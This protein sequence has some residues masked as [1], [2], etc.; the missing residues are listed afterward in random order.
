MALR[1]KF[2]FWG[3]LVPAIIVAAD[4][5]SKAWALGKFGVPHNIC[6]LNPYPQNHIEVSAVFDLS[7]VCNQGVS[8]GL[9]ASPTLLVR[10]LLTLFA[11]GMVVLLLYW[12]NKEREKLISLALALIIGGAIGNAIDRALYGA[13]TDFLNFGDIHFKWV[14]NIADSAI[15]AGV[16]GLLISMLI[17]MRAE[18]AAKN[19]ANSG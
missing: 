10:T 13:V 2:W 17:Q 4:Q 18:K 9:L 7:L 3:G 12:L 14:F 16:I 6:A 1:K 8:F 5:L 15:T 11:A 19:T